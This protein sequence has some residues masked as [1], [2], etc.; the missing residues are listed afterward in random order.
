MSHPMYR[1]LIDHIQESQDG[2][3]FSPI[4]WSPQATRLSTSPLPAVLDWAG[5]DCFGGDHPE[6]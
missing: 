3:V 2:V 6:G 4:Q 1:K 5:G